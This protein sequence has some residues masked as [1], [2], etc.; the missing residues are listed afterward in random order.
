MAETASPKIRGRF[1]TCELV[2]R[3]EL[4]EDLIKFWIKPAQPFAFK[5]GQ[6]C[7]IG[8]DGIE[9]PYSIVSSPDEEDIELFI[10]V[11]PVEHGGHLTPLLDH[12][13]VGAVMTLRPRAKGIFVLQPQFKHHIFVG[14]VTGVVPYL[15]ILRK[16]LN[17]PEYPVPAEGITREDYTFHVLEGASYLDEF[18]YDV[19]LNKLSAEHDFIHFYPSVSRPTEERNAPWTG[20]EGRINLLVEDYVNKLGINPAETCIYACGHP[21]MIEDVG[22]RYADTDYNFVEERFWKEDEA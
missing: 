3:E 13:E 20:A 22:R 21:Q 7:T 16:F 9:R 8:V 15:S 19:E 17:D 2:R 11:V 10:E 14:T 4:T 18:G 12:Q 1:T 6:Y 5:P